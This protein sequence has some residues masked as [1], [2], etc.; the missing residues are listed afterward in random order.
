VTTWDEDK[1]ELEVNIK[2]SGSNEGWVNQR[3]N[4]IDIINALNT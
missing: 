2:V 3:I 1:I 4:E